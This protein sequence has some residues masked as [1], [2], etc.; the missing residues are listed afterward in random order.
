VSVIALSCGSLT[1][2]AGGWFV[3]GGTSVATPMPGF[4]SSA[5]HFVPSS[6]AELP[7]IYANRDR[8]LA[9]SKYYR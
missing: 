9:Q 1:P 2:P 8:A 4:V 3:V 5:G 7:T 6:V